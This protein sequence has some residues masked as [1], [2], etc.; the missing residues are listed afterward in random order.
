MRRKAIHSPPQI[1]TFAGT[2]QMVRLSFAIISPTDGV[3]DV[4]TMMRSILSLRKGVHSVGRIVVDLTPP[5]RTFVTRQRLRK[6]MKFLSK[7]RKVKMTRI[8]E[9]SVPG[10][11]Y[12]WT[13]A[14]EGK[15]ASWDVKSVCADSGV[16]MEYR[17]TVTFANQ[18]TMEDWIPSDAWFRGL[19]EILW[20]NSGPYCQFYADWK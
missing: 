13:R 15:I 14:Y 4:S 12:N 8:Q 10:D 11:M 5:A 17:I 16:P 20:S 9:C 2:H 18:E 7:K 1:A 3:A 6:M 19:C